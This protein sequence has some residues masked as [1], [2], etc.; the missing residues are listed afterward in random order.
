VST[1]AAKVLI[2]DEDLGF[3][4]WLGRV[5]IDAGYEVWPARNT[6]DAATLVNELETR[7]DLLIINPNSKGAEEFVADRRRVNKFKTISIQAPDDGTG[8]LPG[9]DTKLIK[10]LR[11]D[12]ISGLEFLGIVERLLEKGE[13]RN[14]CQAGTIGR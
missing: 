14:S 3:V 12:E 6:A 9:V 5:L 11:P 4:F 1:T 8:S 2:I 13:N 7:M 10:P